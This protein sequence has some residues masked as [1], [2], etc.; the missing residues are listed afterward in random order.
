VKAEKIAK[1]KE[2]DFDDLLKGKTKDQNLAAM[3]KDIYT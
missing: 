1:Q 3:F 2:Q